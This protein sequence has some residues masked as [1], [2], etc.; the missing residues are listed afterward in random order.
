MESQVLLQAEVTTPAALHLIVLQKVPHQVLAL[1][2]HLRLLP[3]MYLLQAH[4]HHHP[5]VPVPHP[6]KVLPEVPLQ[7]HLEAPVHPHPAALVDR[8]VLRLL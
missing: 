1:L 6:L 7:A 8:Q 2:L 3:V 4:Q 5:E